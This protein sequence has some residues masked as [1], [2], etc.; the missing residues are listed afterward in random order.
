LFL[1]A[2]GLQVRAV[3]R[4][5]SRVANLQTEAAGLHL[6]LQAAV[7]DLEVPDV[8]LGEHVY[9]VITVIHYLHRPLFPALVR[10][11]RPGGWLLYETFTIAQARLGRPTNPDFLLL[12]GELARLVEPLEVLRSREGEFEGRMVSAVAARRSYILR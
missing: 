9:D 2:G 12:P 10:A 3:D 5:P 1:A 8:D 7:L 4:D 6:D 11:L